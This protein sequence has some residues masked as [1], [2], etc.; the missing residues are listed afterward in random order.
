MKSTGY[1]PTYMCRKAQVQIHALSVLKK[2][3]ATP[4]TMQRLSDYLDK[5]G[6][7]EVTAGIDVQA[8]A[9]GGSS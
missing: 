6:R 4:E 2:G 5:F 7:P 1:S 8:A 3:T 9:R